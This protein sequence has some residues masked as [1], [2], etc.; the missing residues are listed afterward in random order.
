M[1]DLGRR[2]LLTAGAALT[3]APASLAQAGYPDHA[4]RREA[5]DEAG[6]PAD[7]SAR[8]LAQGLGEELGQRIRMAGAEP[9]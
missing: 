9:R 1:K 4:I 5:A 6:G 7:L 3:V 2:G 8:L